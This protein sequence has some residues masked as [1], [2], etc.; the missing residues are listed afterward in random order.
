MAQC[1]K[2][3]AFYCTCNNNYLYCIDVILACMIFP[4]P[5]GTEISV[6]VCSCKK[7]LLHSTNI[8][9]AT[10]F[11]WVPRKTMIRSWPGNLWYWWIHYSQFS[12]WSPEIFPRTN[13]DERL[14][15]MTIPQA[16]AYSISSFSY[17][18]FCS[19]NKIFLRV[20]PA[21]FTAT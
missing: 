11:S 14:W 20:S 8:C 9:Q 16:F 18:I 19:R 4:L 21:N 1:T 13:V 3:L 12:L 2:A 5:H 10:S 15:W 17:L 6:A 7:Y